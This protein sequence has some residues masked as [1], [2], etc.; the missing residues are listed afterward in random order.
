M[1]SLVMLA[2]SYDLYQ[3]FDLFN[4]V[5][6]EIGSLFLDVYIHAELGWFCKKKVKVK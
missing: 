1:I 2:K 6:A 4:R 5:G 3:F